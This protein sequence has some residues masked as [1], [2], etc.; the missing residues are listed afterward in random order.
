MRSID[1]HAHT[2]TPTMLK[3]LNAGQEWYGMRYADESKGSVYVREGKVVGINRKCTFTPEERVAD[4]D[5]IGTEVQVVSLHTP[6]FGYHLDASAGLAQAQEVNNDISAFAKEA[7][8]RFAG[9]STL[10]MQ[11][12]NAAIA[13]LDR[14]VN[15]LG[16][17]G[18]ELDTVVNG[19]TWDEPEFLPFFKAAESMGAT[20][21]FHPQPQHNLMLERT[22]K[23]A[24]SNSVGVPVE[25]TLLV[26]ALIFGGIMENCPD[27]KVCVAHGGGPACF[28]MGRLDRGWQV[29]SEARVNI[30][31][32]PSYYK[33]RLYYDIVVM[34]ERSLRF[35][36]DAVG[37]ERVVLGS[38]YP[39]VPWD[40][41]PTGWLQ[42]LESLTQE[43]KDQIAWKNLEKLLGIE[44]TGA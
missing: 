4:M 42:S 12:V 44:T 15:T 40:P 21:F 38:D 6:V 28:G 39:F 23:Y 8:S 31:R 17:K 35:L 27:L 1:I 43:E 18:A 7:P 34:S 5:Q 13:E 20:L 3:T 24:L 2:F 33:S 11:D 22:S 9:M 26:A 36:I 32:P 14:A 29:R 30:T 25:D 19:K 16:L 10:P 41:S 37:I